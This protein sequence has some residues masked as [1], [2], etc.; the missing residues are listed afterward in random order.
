MPEVNI[1]KQ[2][3]AET[4]IGRFFGWDPMLEGSL[5]SMNPFAMMRRF[6]EDMEKMLGPASAEMT[7]I[8][9]WRPAIEVKEEKDKLFLKAD[10]PGVKQDDVKVSVTDGMLTVEGER[11]H[12]K[13]AKGEGYYRSERAYGHFCRSIALPEGAKTGEASAQFANGVL[14]VTVPIP[15]RA[16]RRQEI[17]IQERSKTAKTTAH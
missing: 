12:E 7:Q 16:K 5:F 9:E 4:G 13:E 10:L 14:E 6:T 8:A 11:K 17:P 2:P 15:E 1:V 3:K